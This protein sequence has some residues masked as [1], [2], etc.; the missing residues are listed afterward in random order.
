MQRNGI[1]PDF[2]SFEPEKLADA[3]LSRAKELGASHA[4]F[5]FERH[6]SQVVATR[7]RQLEGVRNADEVGF[8]L[9]LIFEGGW[10]FSSDIDL[11]P[12]SAKK[13]ADQAVTVAKQFRALNSE[14]VELAPE[15]SYE[16]THVSS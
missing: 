16:D 5:R 10:G 14:P 8:G 12:E 7:D 9:R 6:R 3:A 2:L 1:D 11:S 4:E 15:P 13:A